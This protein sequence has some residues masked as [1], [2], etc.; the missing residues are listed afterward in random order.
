MKT[1]SSFALGVAL[2]LGAAGGTAILATPAMA[3]KEKAASFKLSKEVQAPLAEAQKL[4]EAGDLNG[5][6]AKANEAVAA[7]K[8]ADDK[9]VAG[10]IFYGIA[11]ARKDQAGLEQ[12]TRLMLDSGKAPEQLKRQL[13]QNMAA[14][15]VQRKD[16]P[17][18]LA[19][20]KALNA[21]YPNDPDIIVSL[22]ELYQYNKLTADAVNTLKQ[23]IDAKKASG[24]PVP[25]SWYQ[26]MLAIAFDA[27][28]ADL[29]VPAS[30]ALLSAYPSQNNWRDSLLIFRDSS[31]L[32]EQ[33]NLDLMRLMRA[34]GALKGENDYYE[35]ANLAYLKGFPGE[36]K[37]VIDEGIA[38]KQLNPG[39]ASF[40]ELSKLSGGKV[41]ADKA[42]LPKLAAQAKSGANGKL[43]LATADAYLG[44]GDY[45]KAI[46]LYRAAL[47]KGGVDANIVNTRLGIAQGRAGDKAAAAAS[48]AKVTG[49]PRATMARYWQAWLNRGA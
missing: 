7:V 18:A 30:F 36:A 2:A 5:A 13:M 46:D 8:S 12:A 43:A 23:A 27:K 21:A 39:K 31:K 45:A 11:A 28:R 41:A 17:G 14:F 35:Y 25:E 24:Q 42:S 22:A 19:Q 1:I 40:A 29:A 33:T 10:Q 38:A 37:A 49:E 26:R 32:D 15:A 34:A 3:A 4:Q 20:F 16:Y 47:A 6:A 9:L 44:Y 48:L